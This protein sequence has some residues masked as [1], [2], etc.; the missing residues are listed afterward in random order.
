MAKKKA[1]KKTAA[2]KETKKAATKRPVPNTPDE[3]SDFM[4]GRAKFKEE[5]AAAFQKRFPR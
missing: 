1:S 5:Q 3:A 2:K 4:K